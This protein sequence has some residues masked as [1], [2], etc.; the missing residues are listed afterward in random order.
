[1]KS[2]PTNKAKSCHIKR[3]KEAIEALLTLAWKKKRKDRPEW[4]IKEVN[5]FY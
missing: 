3:K 2:K 4:L 1:M 5:S